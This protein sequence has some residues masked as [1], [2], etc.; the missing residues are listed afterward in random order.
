MKLYTV[1]MPK[2]IQRLFP[3]YLWRFSSQYKTIY[4]TFDDGPT[5]NITNFVLEQLQKYHAKA[6]FFCIGKNAKNHPE[7]YQNILDGG[8]TVGNHT[9]NHLNG[10]KTNNITYIKNVEEA[11]TNINSKLF[12]PPY[13]R[14]RKKQAKL[15]IQKG[16]KIV[17]W[18]VLS[19]DFDETVTKEKCLT[20]VLKNTSNGSIV[21]LHDSKKCAEKI[22]Y[23]LPK[24]LAHYTKKGYQFKAIS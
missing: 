11:A 16:Y 7:I 17:M 3:D 6:T 19:A 20:N 2:I 8:H 13:G 22:R 15:L 24:V 4:L 12:R 5:E 10:S 14:I 1:K 18:N 23:L 9:N 21:V